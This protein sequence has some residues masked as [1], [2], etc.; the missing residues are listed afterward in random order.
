NGFKLE[1]GRFILDIRKKFFTLRV[2]RHWNRLPREAV[3]AP[4]LEV[5]KARFDGALSNLV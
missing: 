1:E 2:V 5:F 3:E 4:S